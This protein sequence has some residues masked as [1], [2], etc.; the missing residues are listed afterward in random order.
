MVGQ[1]KRVLESNNVRKLGIA[2]RVFV[3]AKESEI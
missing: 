3:R 2:C 1:S